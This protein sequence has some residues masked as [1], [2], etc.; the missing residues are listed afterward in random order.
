MG[1]MEEG[2]SSKSKKSGRHLR[3]LANPLEDEK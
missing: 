1:G 3:C 2:F